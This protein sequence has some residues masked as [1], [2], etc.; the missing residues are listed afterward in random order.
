MAD[1][2]TSREGISLREYIDDKVNAL[3]TRQDDQRRFTDRAVEKAEAALGKR[4]DGM[5][6][7]RDALRDQAARMVTRTEFDALKDRL[8]DVDKRASLTAATV[9]TI[10]GVISSV[11]V[12]VV[13][14]W[15]GK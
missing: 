9:G 2:P 15:V 7:F 4:L 12:G 1:P 13:L 11:I 10:V 8:A 14:R 5:N 3:S 6:E